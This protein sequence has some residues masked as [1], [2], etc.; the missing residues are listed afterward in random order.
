M[1]LRPRKETTGRSPLGAVRDQGYTLAAQPITTAVGFDP[2]ADASQ[3][4]ASQLATV[5]SL[6]MAPVQSVPPLTIE[7]AVTR[8]LALLPIPLYVGWVQLYPRVV[9]VGGTPPD[10]ALPLR[11]G[12]YNGPTPLPSNTDQAAVLDWLTNLATPIHSQYSVTLESETDFV[13]GTPF[14]E[15]APAFVPAGQNVAV[16]YG[17]TTDLA[18]AAPVHAYLSAI[19]APPNEQMLLPRSG[20]S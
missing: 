1:P 8:V 17:L 4:P 11:V 9:L 16:F 15:V 18:Y 7:P 19:A 14:S 5:G 12:Y 3:G 20:V 10:D 13:F 2:L 6:I